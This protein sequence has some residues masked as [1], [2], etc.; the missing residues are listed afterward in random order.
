[1]NHDVHQRSEEL[2]IVQAGIDNAPDL[3][4]IPSPAHES[5]HAWS[6][7][8][9]NKSACQYVTHYVRTCELL[10]PRHGNADFSGSVTA[11]EQSNENRQLERCVTAGAVMPTRDTYILQR[12]RSA[13][14][15]TYSVLAG[16]MGCHRRGRE[17]LVKVNM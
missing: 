13:A 8:A 4:S 15:M 16:R 9:G 3:A 7:A 6:T 1:M 11:Q 12:V 5:V 10:A 2:G 17:P 14:C